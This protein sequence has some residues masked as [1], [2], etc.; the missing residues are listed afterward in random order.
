[1]RNRFLKKK[2]KMKKKKRGT[3]ILFYLLTGAGVSHL[4]Q[5]VI[6][7]N[8]KGSVRAAQISHEE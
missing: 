5:S 7:H 1:M 6:R 3:Q 4:G 2:K 8:S